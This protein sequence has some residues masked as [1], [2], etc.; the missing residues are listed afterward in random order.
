MAVVSR[1]LYRALLVAGVL[2]TIFAGGC[3]KK[4]VA[5]TPPPPAPVEQPKPQP[6]VTLSAD[7]TSIN[8]GDSSTLSWS[9][10]NATQLTIAP[11]VG[12]VTAEGS[13]KV[14]PSDSTTY[15]ITASGPGG[16]ATSTARVTVSTPAPPV[17]PP[18]APDLDALFLKEVRD[19]YFDFNKAD[20]RADAR[21][22]LTK[23]A[24]FLRNNPGIRVTIE[25]HC[26]E[27][28][29]T[30]YNLALGDRRAGAVKQYLVSLG[31]SADRISTVSFGKEKPFC[32]QSNESC[33]QQNRRGHFVRA[34]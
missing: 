23:T 16:S 28:G 14:T 20:V 21:D 7:P 15:T 30:E 24:E 33:W 22:A 4:P 2:A 10:T 26:D 9:S 31:I 17:E 29:S 27:R 12:T 13:T 34:Q 8:K 25:G 3:K 6:T 11:E 19:A 5:T 18:P 1:P 32:T